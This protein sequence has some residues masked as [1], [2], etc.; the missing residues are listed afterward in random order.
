MHEATAAQSLTHSGQMMGTLDYMAP[1]QAMDTHNASAQADIYSLGCTLFFLLTGEPVYPGDTVATKLFAHRE[2]PIPS[3]SDHRND[4]SDQ[5]Q[6]TFTRMLAKEPEG[7]QESMAE[8]ISELE[9]CRDLEQAK[10]D[11]ASLS[12]AGT[13]D[14]SDIAP[15][16][17]DRDMTVGATPPPAAL[18]SGSSADNWLDAELPETPTVLRRMN[19]PQAREHWG[20]SPQVIL[21]ISAVGAV[22]LI[23]LVL[24]LSS[25][26]NSSDEPP[27]AE[28]SRPS[29]VVE[30]WSG[31]QHPTDAEDAETPSTSVTQPVLV[32]R[33][34]PKGALRLAIG[35]F[36]PE[37]AR[38]HQQAWAKYLGVPVEL[39]N[40][41]GMRLV[42]IPP[43]E[44]LMGSTEVEQ[45]PAIQSAKSSNKG[46]IQSSVA[47]I[48][49]EG[50]R[51]RV[52]VTRAFYLSKH[53]VT[54][55][56]FRQFVNETRYKTDAERDGKGGRGAGF[57]QDPQFIWS[58]D[59]GFPQTD[60]HPTVNVSWNDA[61]AFCNWLSKK[62]GD[63]N[64]L[65]TE[66]QW[67]YACRAGT[68]T[69]WH[70]GDREATLED[71]AWFM[72][73]AGGMTHAVGQLE[74][75]AWGL[76]DMH[77]NVWEWCSDWYAEDYYARSPEDDPRGPE[78]GK[79]RVH[80]S[81]GWNFPAFLCRSAYR[82]GHPA[83]FRFNNLG[84]RVACAVTDK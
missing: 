50:P 39:T 3:L 22:A 68:A 29:A 1:E 75:N 31:E 6:A 21:A 55:G 26:F 54:R 41:I 36:G 66:A 5:L 14:F 11:S 51:H 57:R 35:S 47:N 4:I 73:N 81:S 7:R 67:E 42:L 58:A 49:S 65:P 71:S 43:G 27:M 60:E 28:N 63:A 20:L 16:L 9:A 84:F 32:S 77:G 53:E 38:Q 83:G 12:L 64:S 25:A 37:E 18:G 69:L 23:L 40:S 10:E 70:I 48:Q 76:Y 56:Q 15:A 52:R 8:V 2:Q 44:F 82:D 61:T 79:D 34:A 74:P 13:E 45:A 17:A 78:R 30:G 33:S 72:E 80:R 59:P 19:S 24:A 62:Q 46:L